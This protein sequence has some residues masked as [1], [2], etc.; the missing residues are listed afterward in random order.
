MQILKTEIRN[1]ILSAARQEFKL[2]GFQKSTI[3]SIAKTAEI[4]DGN[5]YRYFDSKETLLD[6]VVK[7]AHDNIFD[8]IVKFRKLKAKDDTISF[9]DFKENITE[10]ISKLFKQHHDEIII[11]FECC[12]GTKYEIIKERIINIVE[13]F[14]IDYIKKS[15]E[16]KINRQYKFISFLIAKGFIEG[17]LS[18]HK[19][20]DNDKDFDEA[21]NEF[22][23]FYF[24]GFN[25]RFI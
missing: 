1:N 14:L 4:S 20:Y 18:I 19:Q 5:I 12:K 24:R 25:K 11:I 17:L 9:L 7:P 2:K 15:D 23:N 22:N 16:F 10:S 8:L 3:R 21:L 6:D 13:L